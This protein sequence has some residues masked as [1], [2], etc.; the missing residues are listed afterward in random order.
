MSTFLGELELSQEQLQNLDFADFDRLPHIELIRS[1][2]DEFAQ[3]V[4]LMPYQKD[5]DVMRLL[6]SVYLQP[7]NS[8][9]KAIGGGRVIAVL[10]REPYPEDVPGILQIVASAR[11]RLASLEALTRRYEEGSIQQ[12][13]EYLGQ[14]CS[15]IENSHQNN[16]S[17][18]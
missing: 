4:E 7:R 13:R 5:G 18:G 15:K 17:S 2:A 16:A 9:G 3:G 12:A 10:T 8:A 6:V 14:L 1:L 11:R